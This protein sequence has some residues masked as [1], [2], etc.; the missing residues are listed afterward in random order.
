MLQTAYANN[1]SIVDFD[2]GKREP[3]FNSMAT[4]YPG[5]VATPTSRPHIPAALLIGHGRGY[6]VVGRQSSD[7]MCN[8]RSEIASNQI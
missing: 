1:P 4:G 6:S 5:W 3:L 2:S 8:E 7:W